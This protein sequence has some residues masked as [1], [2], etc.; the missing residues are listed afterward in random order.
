M[1][2]LIINILSEL[3]LFGLWLGIIF[4]VHPGIPTMTALY[5]ALTIYVI[6]IIATF[7]IEQIIKWSVKKYFDWKDSKDE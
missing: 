7:A 2:N 6:S 4:L 5:I 1:K 3:F